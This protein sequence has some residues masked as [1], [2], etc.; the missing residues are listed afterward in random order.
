MTGRSEPAAIQVRPAVSADLELVRQVLV[1]TWHDTYDPLLGRDRVTEITARWHSVPA[2]A[3]QYGAGDTA[4][5]VAEAEGRIVGHAF[6]DFR[7]P[8]VARLMRLYVLPAWQR[9]GI[10]ARLLAVGLESRPGIERVALDVEVYN[11]KAVNFY[12]GQGFVVVGRASA[13]GLDCLQMEL[14][15]RPPE[16]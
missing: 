6:V 2:L 13:E 8:P 3:A 4:F 16:S 5:L 14:V 7:R 15:R 1:E 10:G 11:A 12:R 9:R